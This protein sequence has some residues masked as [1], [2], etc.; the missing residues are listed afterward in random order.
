MRPPTSRS[1]DRLVS[2]QVLRW[3]EQERRRNEA[4][5]RPCIAISRLPGAGAGEIGLR[6]AEALGYGFFG[7]EIVDQIARASR[8]RRELVA[9]LDERVHDGI[10]RWV[11]D[12]VRRHA[13]DESHYLRELLRTL[14]TL[15]ERG[16]AVV[17]GRGSPYVLPAERT[18]R[19]FVV[20]S[21]PA[22]LERLAKAR[23]LP[24]AEAERTLAR[25]ENERVAFLRRQF[26]VDPDDSTHYDLVVNTDAFGI[27]GA[28]ELV[29]HAFGLRFPAER[30]GES[31]A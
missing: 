23:R 1:L 29:K 18:L 25:E 9:D 4:R 19:V 15:S 10:E 28:T 24:E 13:F 8:V 14:A 11:T 27:D 17:L 26:R 5:P 21:R 12:T 31:K 7:I 22:R 20:A 30:R 2:E 6:V 16:Q 3:Q